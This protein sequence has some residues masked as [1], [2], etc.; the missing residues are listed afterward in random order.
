MGLPVNVGH[1]SKKNAPTFPT[2]W[3]KLGA[4]LHI[5]PDH[6]IPEPLKGQSANMRHEYVR[7]LRRELFPIGTNASPKQQNPRYESGDYKEPIC[8][9]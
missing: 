4:I 2:S 9:K 1:A 7:R 3:G 6:C 8:P 5:G